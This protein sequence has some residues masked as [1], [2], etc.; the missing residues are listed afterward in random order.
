MQKWHFLKLLIVKILTIEK[1]LACCTQSGCSDL[2]TSS[3]KRAI[4]RLVEAPKCLQ[5]HR[6][7]LT[8]AHFP[9]RFEYVSLQGRPVL[10]H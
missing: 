3:R 8:R 4:E 9:E 6:R 7:A 10:Q 1:Y 2:W 5:P